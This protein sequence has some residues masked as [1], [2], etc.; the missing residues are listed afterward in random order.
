MNEK[1]PGGLRGADHIAYLTWKPKETI[2]F[3]RDVLGLPLMHCIVAPG[4]G[5]DP[6]PDFVHFFFDIGAGGKIAFFYYFG[7]EPTD[8]HA[9]PDLLGKVRHL[10]LLV[11]TE[12]ELDAYEERI[13][14][15][16]YP[17]RHRVMHEL[18]ESIYMFD[19]NGYNLEISRPLRPIGAVDQA[20]AA[21][22]AQALCDVIGEDNPTLERLLQRKGELILADAAT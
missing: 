21:L 1:L 19:P 11:D 10:A 5:N 6:H 18:I 17:L 4:W 16:G 12:E 22:S 14:D 8:V 13:R 15:A 2:E 9:G 7:M 20:D 3:Y